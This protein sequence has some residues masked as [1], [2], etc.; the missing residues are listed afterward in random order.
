M[1][2]KAGKIIGFVLGMFLAFLAI[3][4]LSYFHPEE[5]F[6]GIMIFALLISGLFF[7]FIGS[8]FQN[9]FVNKKTRN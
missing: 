7:S 4:T 1:K 5:D 9:Y 8:L 6:A 3:A 2:N